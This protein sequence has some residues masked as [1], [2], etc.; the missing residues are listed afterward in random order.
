MHIYEIIYQQD[1][2]IWCTLVG[3]KSLSPTFLTLLVVISRDHALVA[4]L[5]GTLFPVTYMWYA[6]TSRFCRVH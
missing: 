3:H 2:P 6:I 4:P 5:L 1:T